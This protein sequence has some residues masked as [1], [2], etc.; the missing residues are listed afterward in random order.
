MTTILTITN[1]LGEALKAAIRDGGQWHLVDL[2]I[3]RVSW[4]TEQELVTA[5]QCPAIA[6]IYRDTRKVVETIR[7]RNEDGTAAPGYALRDFMFDVQIWDKAN[8][9]EELS[10]RLHGAGDVVI[11][12]IEDE[13]DLD[14]RSVMTKVERGS[15]TETFGEGSAQMAALPLQVTVQTYMLQGDPTMPFG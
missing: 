13:W 4:L 2:P 3:D 6:I 9:V 5:N 15:Q 14:G 8:R 11:A 10:A 7:G 1:E 12:A